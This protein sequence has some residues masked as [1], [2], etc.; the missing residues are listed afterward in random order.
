MMWMVT[1]SNRT[2]A[3]SR[4]PQGIARQMLNPKHECPFLVAYYALV[5]CLGRK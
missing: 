1:V 4:T 2:Y 5:P 3:R